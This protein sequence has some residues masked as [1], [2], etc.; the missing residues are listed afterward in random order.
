MD[1]PKGM[2]EF[3]IPAAQAHEKWFVATEPV[4]YPV[5]EF[6]KTLN[7]FTIGALAIVF[8]L[9]LV[10]LW[11]NKEYDEST[12]G[13]RMEAKI[14]PWRD[15]AAGVL[16][17]TM[18][19][20]LVWMSIEGVHL[21]PNYPF[22]PDLFG[23][24]LRYA[25]AAIGVLLMIGLFTPAASIGLLALY[26]SAFF[27]HNSIEPIDYINYVGIAIFLLVFSRGR[28][29]LDW[30]LGKPILST[31]QQ[32][33][34][35]YQALRILTGFALVWLALLKWRRPDLHLSLM[36]RYAEFN[37][38]VILG[39]FNI[40][41]SRE[42]YVFCLTVVEAT[43]GIFEM[44]GILTRIT[45]VMLVPIMLGSIIFLGPGELVGH[46]PILGSLFVL[47]VYGDDYYKNRLPDR[48]A[49]H[50]GKK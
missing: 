50:G 27:L 19:F 40:H 39:W 12:F 46:L 1:F 10:G 20:T 49:E 23:N 13:H 17:V 9:A 25:Q 36:D 33:K 16:A 34:R 2:L 37:P 42:M 28:Y 21:A 43:V 4:T 47:F 45:S 5:P 26:V 31:P 35:A 32:R 18:G 29:S 14:R 22:T 48:Y 6:F 15:Y 24:V 38:Y 8:V 44:F 30:F 11:L 7:E 41:M 3:V